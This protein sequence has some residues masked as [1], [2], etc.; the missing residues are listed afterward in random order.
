MLLFVSF[1]K[2]SPLGFKLFAAL[3]RFA[4]VCES[5]FG[6]VELFVFRPAEVPL[7]FL[8]RVFARRVAVRLARALR[9]HA[10]P[11]NCFN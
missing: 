8:H 10:K 11:D 2:L 3:N 7:R 6:N 1:N 4:E 9:R 5:F